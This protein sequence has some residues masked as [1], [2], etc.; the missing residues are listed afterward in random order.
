MI[1]LVYCFS[2]HMV[3]QFFCLALRRTMAWDVCGVTICLAGVCCLRC[4]FGVDCDDEM[5]WREICSASVLAT[6]GG[7]TVVCTLWGAV[8]SI[9]SLEVSVFFDLRCC[10][11]SKILASCFKA[12]VC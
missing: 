12:I 5:G 9:P 8:F 4:E 3:G 1:C 10:V 11:P 7:E 2:H 6:L